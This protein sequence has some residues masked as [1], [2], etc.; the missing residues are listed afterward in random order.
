[1]SR[2]LLYRSC[3]KFKGYG[4]ARIIH[5][6]MCLYYNAETVRQIF[7]RWTTIVMRL[8][9]DAETPHWEGML[10]A[11][12]LSRCFMLHCIYSVYLCIL[13]EYTRPEREFDFLSLSLSHLAKHPNRDYLPVCALDR[14]VMKLTSTL[15]LRL[16]CWHLINTYCIIH[17]SKYNSELI[18]IWNF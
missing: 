2:S 6:T 4:F 15:R 10:I 11:Y 5:I 16:Y 7:H 3:F 18:R 8:Y 13:D 1:M 12:C 14:G 17:R 9:T